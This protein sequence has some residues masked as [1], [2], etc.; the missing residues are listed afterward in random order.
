MG[1]LFKSK[2]IVAENFNPACAANGKMYR[3]MQYLCVNCILEA[4][5]LR[6]AGFLHIYI[7]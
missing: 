1:A 2:C 7:V 6:V 5:L 3:L 4:K